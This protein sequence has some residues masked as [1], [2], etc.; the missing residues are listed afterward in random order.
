MAAFSQIGA[1]M[2][3][4]VWKLEFNLVDGEYRVNRE[5]TELDSI[6][7]FGD[8]LLMLLPNGS[9]LTQMIGPLPEKIDGKIAHDSIKT[10]LEIRRKQAATINEKA[11]AG[12][13]FAVEDVD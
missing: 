1:S 3:E 6:L 4:R 7:A 13:M 2:K 10:L 8:C 11:I 5:N 12:L 9:G